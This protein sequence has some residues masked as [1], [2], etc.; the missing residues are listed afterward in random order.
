MYYLEVSPKSDKKYRITTP[1]GKKIDFGASGYSDF[2]LHKDP[3]RQANYISRHE[4]RENW[5]ETG[6]DTAGF[7]ARWILWNLP[8]LMQ[9][10]KDTER[11]F[12]IQI[13]TSLK[14]ILVPTYSTKGEKD[15]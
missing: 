11:R 10:V 7:W 6:K 14:K 1:Y 8:D 9:S 12:N 4:S 2:T 5:T 15:N 13:D 3:N